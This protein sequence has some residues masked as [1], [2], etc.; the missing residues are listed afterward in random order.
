MS[1]GTEAAVEP[2]ERMS[3]EQL[4]GLFLL[5]QLSDA[6]LDWFV[7]HG[8]VVRVPAGEYVFRAE[9]QSR[10]FYQL[11][12]GGIVLL[13]LID[14]QEVE[15]TRTEQVGAYGGATTNWLT[16]DPDASY[17]RSMR[18][19]TD[20]VLLAVPA[21]GFS[22]FM[23]EH[24]NI[25]VHL[26]DG[27]REG[28][29]V[30]HERVGERQRLQALGS[31]AAGLTHELNNPAAAAERAV[32]QL[33][34]RVAGMRSKL[35]YLADGHVPAEVL[36]ELVDLQEEALSLLATAPKRTALEASDAEDELADWFDEQ[37]LERAASLAPVFVASGLDRGWAEKVQRTLSPT[38]LPSGFAWVA[39][40]LETESLM[41]EITD[42]TQRIAHLVAAAKGYSQLDRAPFQRV[43]VHDGLES[44]LIML[45][46][47]L[48]HT[49]VVEEFDRTLPLVPCYPAELN[50]VWTNLIDNAV[51]AMG[52]GGTLTLRTSLEDDC[53]LVSVGDTGP[54]VPPELVSR[55]FEP[56]FTTKA[57]GEGTGLGLDISYR[58]V[59]GRH[60]GDLRVTGG[61]GDT[62]FEVR[63]PLT[64]RA[65]DPTG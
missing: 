18:A 50:Q 65:S 26:L 5:E 55:I 1:D 31:L 49:T 63:L 6:Q 3:R 27:L 58:L 9:E 20:A 30:S 52:D 19:L 8:E 33:R 17:G 7:E 46:T 47:K 14:G 64:E 36:R 13:A 44:T 28:M 12:E 40:S 22:A 10:C 38:D 60:G 23:R 11:V 45:S 29:R 53:A 51:Q 42:S 15:V 41:R 16:G 39:Y 62:R 4:R 48:K 34:G 59:V 24:F 37:G 35:G 56:F 57:V 61:P 54:G 43:D 2:V 32:D 25:A 21:Q